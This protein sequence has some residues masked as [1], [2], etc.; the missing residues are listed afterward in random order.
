MAFFGVTYIEEEKAIRL[1]EAI[2]SFVDAEIWFNSS[3][4]AQ[5]LR[6]EEEIEAKE[7][8]KLVEQ[9]LFNRFYIQT[10]CRLYR[11]GEKYYV[12]GKILR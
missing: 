12:N 5:G 9:E 1:A 2:L 10:K 4:Y 11:V 3:D 6:E 7:N 8:L